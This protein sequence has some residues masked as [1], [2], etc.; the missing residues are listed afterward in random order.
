MLLILAGLVAAAV[1]A[2]SVKLHALNGGLPPQDETYA[3][4]LDRWRSTAELLMLKQSSNDVPGFSR[5]IDSHVDTSGDNLK[6]WSG[7]VTADFVNHIGGIDRT[8]IHYAF[9]SLDGDLDCSQNPVPAP[10][11]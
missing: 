9:N 3:H 1:W 2:W 10:G 8:N 4:K 7:E 6:S 11:Q 5:L